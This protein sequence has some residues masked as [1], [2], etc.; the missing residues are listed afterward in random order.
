MGEEVVGTVTDYFAKINVAGVQ[1]SAPLQVGDT[2]HIRGH[3]T[4]LTQTVDSIQIDKNAVP[5]AE[6]GTLVG[7]R[8]KER[9]RQHDKVFRVAPES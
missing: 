6:A 7:I 5:R 3:T 2:I 1:L 4:D 8:V 9:V